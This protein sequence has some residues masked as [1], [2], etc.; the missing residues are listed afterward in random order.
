GPGRGATVVTQEGMGLAADP[1]NA[2]AVAKV[3]WEMRNAGQEKLVLMGEKGQA[4]V[5]A[6]HS[7]KATVESIIHFIRE[8]A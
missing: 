3:V 7:R 8:R 2:E 5:K 4:W 6:N 1:E